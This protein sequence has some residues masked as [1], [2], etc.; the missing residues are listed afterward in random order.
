VAWSQDVSPVRWLV[1]KIVPIA[2]AVVGLAVV[3]GV[4]VAGL[5]DRLN[6]LTGPYNGYGPFDSFHFEA[7]VPLQVAY[8]VFG[9]ALGLA[10]SALVRRTVPAMA[11]AAAL[12]IGARVAVWL[13]RPYLLSPVRVVGPAFSS[14][15]FGVGREQWYL[16]GGYLNSAGQVLTNSQLVLYGDPTSYGAYRDSLRR[17]GVTASFVDYQPADR[18]VTMRLIE[19]GIFVALAAALFVVVWLRLRRSRAS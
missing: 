11:G 12:F 10:M 16:G 17:D 2:V 8:A 4:A 3:L 9:L 18:L 19:T 14:E 13:V 15:E 6:T 1:G 7:F 5:G